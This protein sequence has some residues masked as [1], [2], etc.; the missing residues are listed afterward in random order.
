M[1]LNKSQRWPRRA[2]CCS[3][4]ASRSWRRLR[5]DAIVDLDAADRAVKRPITTL[6]QELLSRIPASG[7]DARVLFGDAFSEASWM[8]DH[9]V[10][11]LRRPDRVGA[12][13][14][15]Y[16]FQIKVPSKRAPNGDA[17]GI[18]VIGNDPAAGTV[19]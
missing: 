2:R 10:L 14:S 11:R 9:E 17:E 16:P 5:C 19:P 12:Q 1:R 3:P 8:V 13:D 15:S 7:S 6:R 4:V 18:H